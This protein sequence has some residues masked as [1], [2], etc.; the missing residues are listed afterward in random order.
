MVAVADTW[1]LPQVNVYYGNNRIKDASWLKKCDVGMCAIYTLGLHTLTL[2]SLAVLT[3]YGTLAAEF[4]TRGKGKNAR[5]SL[6][7]PLGCL[8]SVPWCVHALSQ[9][10]HMCRSSRP[11]L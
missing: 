8:E 5:A 6:S 11:V 3:T 10:A 2:L 1:A 4:V 7:R 9:S